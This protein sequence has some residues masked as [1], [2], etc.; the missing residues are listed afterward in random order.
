MV[1]KRVGPLSVAKNVAV[2]YAIS[3]VNQ[4]CQKS[5]FKSC[6]GY[7]VC[8]N[9]DSVRRSVV[10]ASAAAARSSTRT[11]CPELDTPGHLAAIAA[12]GSSW[13]VG[14]TARINLFHGF[15]DK[16]RLAEAREQ[17]RLGAS[18]RAI[19]LA[20]IM[21]G[22]GTEVGESTNRVILES[23]VF[24]GPTIRNAA[25]RLGLRS[26]ASMR[27]EKGIGHDLPRFA[28]DR[29]AGLIAEITTFGHALFPQFGLPETLAD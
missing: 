6:Q 16:A 8:A 21:G 28:L 20:G 22:A 14:A 13:V 5:E 15:A 19:G 23:A 25:R 18:E 10:R 1:V 4:R 11:S 7:F 2:L 3:A 29:A 9:E 12:D 27:H 17:G 24:H 26:E